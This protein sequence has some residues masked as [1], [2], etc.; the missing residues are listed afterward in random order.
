MS[1]E[2][3]KAEM[4]VTGY[5]N[6]SLEADKIDD[7]TDA[8]IDAALD[9]AI[10][11]DEPKENIGESSSETQEPVVQQQQ[12]ENI[13]EPQQS[14][15]EQ[16][17]QTEG[18]Q[19]AP[20]QIEIDPE[21]QAIEQPRNLSEKNQSNWRKLQ[22]TASIYKKQAAE[23]EALRQKI[24]EYESKPPVP[25][26][27]EDLKK[28]RAFVDIQSDPEFQMRYSQP[29]DAAKANIYNILKKHGASD[30]VIASIEKNGG[31]DK[32]ASDWWKTNAIDKLPIADAER[33]KRSL[34]EV[35]D[36]QERR[37]AEI[38][39]AAHNADQ[40]YQQ[41]SNQAVNWYNEQNTEVEKYI[42]NRIKE[43]KADWALP[44]EIPQNATPEEKAAIQKHNEQ[45]ARLEQTFSS[46]LF[47]NT[48]QERAD[49]AAA[50]AMS[51]LLVDQLRNEQAERIRLTEQLQKL[52][53]EN[54]KLKGA[55]K[56]PRQTIST[57]G[58]NKSMTLNDRLK[59]SSSDAID[60]GL[61]EAGA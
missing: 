30:E 7:D 55:G 57:Q 10:S 24:T 51:H 59:M 45:A 22:E 37:Q 52:S 54:T 43:A 5:G 29:I 53:S 13:E 32:V 34:V 58:G 15:P 56:L 49:V 26:D 11:T 46:A 21:I 27:Y 47:P 28:F 31:P 23:A 42:V 33:L 9:A 60:I 16:Q 25:Q 18:Q 8:A 36:L 19:Q 14:I 1:D 39:Q 38:V 48:P 44:R 40:Y 50:A 6:P 2:N 61:E 3:E 4:D 12:E 20:P 17:Q 41:K 35:T